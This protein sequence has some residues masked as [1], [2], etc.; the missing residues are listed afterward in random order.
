[1]FEKEKYEISIPVFEGPM[2]LLIYLVNKN[3]ID[4][5][6]IPI[7]LI[8]E[9]YLDY[10]H[11]A[12]EFNLPLGSEFFEM[13]A[14]LLYIKS[15]TLLPK[16]RQ[17][18]GESEDPREELAR[19]LEEFKVM[20]EIKA[21][22]DSLIEEQKPY[23]T[24][25]PLEIKSKVFNGQIPLAKLHAAFLA[26]QEEMEI[27]EEKVCIREEFTLDDAVKSLRQVIREFHCVS[28]YS[29]FKKQ[30]T[31]LRLAVSLVALLEL[32]R[33]GEVIIEDNDSELVIK[34]TV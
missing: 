18:N 3:R 12:D 25:E 29:F 11:D 8:T 19:S 15:K 33:I 31:R 13:A 10:L 26:L 4:I 28:V 27:K 6:D 17:E 9:Q 7:H 14:N 34:E 21:R 2:D 16:R 20:K 22:I 1:M 5:H 32:M 23:R 30:Y 24:R